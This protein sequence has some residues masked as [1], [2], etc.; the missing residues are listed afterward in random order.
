MKLTFFIPRTKQIYV[1]TLTVSEIAFKMTVITS[2][3]LSKLLLTS[4]TIFKQRLLH[5][6]EIVQ[7]LQNYKYHDKGHFRKP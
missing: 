2:W 7:Y 6:N 3:T 4:A 1:K 5:E